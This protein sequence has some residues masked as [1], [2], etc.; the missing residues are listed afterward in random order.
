L[1]GFLLALAGLFLFV[2]P[3]E[4]G[5]PPVTSWNPLAVAWMAPGPIARTGAAVVALFTLMLVRMDGYGGTSLGALAVLAVAYPVIARRYPGFETLAVIAALTVLAA[6]AAWWLPGNISLPEPLY[7][8]E[9]RA[10]GTVPGPIIPPELVPFLSVTSAFAAWF[11]LGGFV[12][13]W[14]A[15]RPGFWAVCRR[16]RRFCCSRLPTGG[17]RP[18]RST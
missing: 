5:A 8:I 7:I 16:P 13:L 9:G 10:H 12:A 4:A 11:G 14:G 6:M 2:L 3:R 17:S 15:A 1:A 18:S